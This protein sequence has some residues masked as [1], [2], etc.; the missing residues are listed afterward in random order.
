VSLHPKKPISNPI[1]R[2]YFFS[3]KNSRTLNDVAI[4]CKA[5]LGGP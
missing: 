2:T 1:I 4:F 3:P 5:C